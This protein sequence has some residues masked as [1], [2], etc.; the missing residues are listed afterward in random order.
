M[1]I[2]LIGSQTLG[3]ALFQ[4]ELGRDEVQQATGCGGQFC[5]RWRDWPVGVDFDRLSDAFNEAGGQAQEVR[6]LHQQVQALAR[7]KTGSGLSL[8][9]EKELEQLQ[10]K[11][12][13]IVASGWL[14][15][16]IMINAIDR[17]L[18]PTD[19]ADDASREEMQLWEL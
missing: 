7:R 17:P 15:D 13:D 3:Q 10:I 8:A 6:T 1:R 9:E 2:G 18:L 19:A 5:D 4:I 16:S 11:L 12:D 14:I